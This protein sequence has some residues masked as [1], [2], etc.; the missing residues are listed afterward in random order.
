MLVAIERA[1]EAD[2]GTLDGLEQPESLEAMAA[3]E[4][5]LQARLASAASSR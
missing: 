2:P 1:L 5:D 3:Y 4:D